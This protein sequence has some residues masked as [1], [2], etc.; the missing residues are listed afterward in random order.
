MIEVNGLVK[1]FGDNVA[2]DGLSFTVK[3]GEILGFLGPN[4]AGKSTTMNMI[5][6]YISSTEGSVSIDGFDVFEQ[7]EEAK[8]RIGYLPEQPPLYMDMTVWEYLKFVADLKGVKKAEQNKM[9]EDI[10]EETKI[11]NVASR[12]IRH[13]SKG[14]KQR[15]GI[16]G[17]IMGYPAVIIL[18]E[19]TVGLDP[20]Q[21]IEIRSLIQSLAKKHTVILS[22]HI[23]PEVSA[24]CERVLIINKGKLIAD[25][26]PDQLS[27]HLTSTGGLEVTVKGD[28]AQIVADIEALT[29]IARVIVKG[30]EEGLVQL[31]LYTENEADV[32]EEF[33]YEMARLRHPIYRMERIHLSLEEIFLEL[34]KEDAEMVKEED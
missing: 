5:T 17:A 1:R 31:E 8:K 34:T 4:G 26:T 16:A 18:D 15:V 23:L 3:K 32:R 25:D 2:V 33:F 11:T 14:Y 21:M 22:S 9:I 29:Y 6:G 19:P 20:K 28:K 7:P 12:L 27:R 10:M 30:E 24:V 13:L